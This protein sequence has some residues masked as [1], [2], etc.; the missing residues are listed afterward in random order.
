MMKNYIISA[1]AV[2]ASFLSF[3]YEAQ[4]STANTYNQASVTTQE[5]MMT[6]WVLENNNLASEATVAAVGTEVKTG[7]VLTLKDSL[8]Y[9]YYSQTL[10]LKLDYQEDQALLK[11]VTDWIGTPYRSGGSTKKG[12]DC[13]GFV[14]NVF[15][16]V[17]GIT[18]THSSRS[19][20]TQVKR[21]AKA[22]MNTGDLVFFR[23]GP[24]QPIYHVGIYLKDGKFIHSASR[25]GVM[26]NSLNSAY[27]KKYFYAAG[28]AI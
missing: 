16:Q 6:E 23:R 15:K 28:R 24:G 27:Y 25:G 12:T 22:T 5:E 17:Y 7:K 21:V 4:S 26:I 19:M 10:G 2:T 14:S 20:F 1:L 9:S 13:S 8:F 3:F 18:L 11:T